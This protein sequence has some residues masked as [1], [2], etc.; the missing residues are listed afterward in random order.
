MLVQP[1]PWPNSKVPIEEK[2][3]FRSKLAP[4]EK[5]ES[6][7]MLKWYVMNDAEYTLLNITEHFKL[8]LYKVEVLAKRYNWAERKEAFLAWDLAWSIERERETRHIEHREKLEA[9][10]LRTEQI[11]NGMIQS[12]AQ[13]LSLCNK[14]MLI[15]SSNNEEIDRR[16]LSSA[17]NAAAKVADAGRMMAGQSIGVDAVL[18]AI[19]DSSTE[20]GFQ[21]DLMKT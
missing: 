13:L 11:G 12:A 14:T 1:D 8:P 6:W 9:F 19:D 16:L 10:R 20:A 17:L 4:T 5:N 3:H 18:G 15:M 2:W 7:I 21:D